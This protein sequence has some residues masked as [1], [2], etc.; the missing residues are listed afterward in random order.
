M[1]AAESGAGPIEDSTPPWGWGD[2]AATSD[3][4]PPRRRWTHVSAWATIGLITG[5][6]AVVAS[7]TGLLAPEGVALGVLSMIICLVGWRSVRRTHVTGHSLVLI[8][9]LAAL[10]AIVI[11]VLA[12]T[13]DIA[14]FTTDSDQ[15][16]R[17]HAWL[18]QHWPWLERW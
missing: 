11:G 5:L 4:T 17:L 10:A 2:D 6:V 8:G 7:L 15:V 3:L 13:G 12:I 18:D 9:L 14:W 1:S 16:G